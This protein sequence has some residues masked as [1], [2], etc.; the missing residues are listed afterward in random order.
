M[1]DRETLATDAAAFMLER[2]IANA[3]EQRKA[4]RPI[5]SRNAK[6]G[7]ARGK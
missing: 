1:W 3:C 2:Q 7:I 5:Y 4:E 6:K